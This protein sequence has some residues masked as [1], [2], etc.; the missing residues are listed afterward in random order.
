MVMATR[1]LNSTIHLPELGKIP[2]P[3]RRKYEAYFCYRFME[4]L[5]TAY[6]AKA[7]GGKDDL[8][9]KWKDLKQTTH[10]YKP[11][12]KGEASTYGIRQYKSLRGLLSPSLDR[13]WRLTFFK[14]YRAKRK[15]LGDSQAKV[16]AAKVAWEVVKQKG[17]KT[18]KDMLSGRRTLINVRTGRLLAAFAPGRVSQD[19]YISPNP[20]QTVRVVSGALYINI[21]VPYAEH[22]HSRRPLI[23]SNTRP[24]IR[25]AHRYALVMSQKAN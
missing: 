15:S 1:R 22:V 4:L 12:Q 23:P 10:I 14:V 2:P 5:H 8:G 6:L 3:N 9:N 19:Q 18:K 20:D 16:V 13:L 17:G 11:L 21:R 24:W 25:D 7:V